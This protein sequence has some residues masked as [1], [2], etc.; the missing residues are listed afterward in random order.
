MTTHQF[1]ALAPGQAEETR[2]GDVTYTRWHLYDDVPE[3]HLRRGGFVSHPPEYPEAVPVNDLAGCIILGSAPCWEADLASARVFAPDW[4]VVAVNGVGTLYLDRIEAWCSIHGRDLMKWVP[5]R[6]ERGGNTDYAGY[7]NFTDREESG[8]IIRWNRPNSGGSSGLHA[9]ELAME[10]GY[11]KIILC[12]MPLDGQQRVRSLDGIAVEGVCA[13]ASY[14]DGWNKLLPEMHGR[15]RSMSGW[16]KGLLG[17]PTK[18]W[19]K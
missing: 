14:Q 6:E 15:V 19:I 1:L 8:N 18:G 9:V 10:I 7:G 11:E 16:T 3:E 17:K 4:P 12:G 5:M 2:I 13:Y